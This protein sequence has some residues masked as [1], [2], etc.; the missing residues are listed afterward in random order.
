MR[1][2]LLAL[3][4][5]C[6]SWSLEA[7]TRLTPIQF[8]DRLTA[9][10]DSLFAGGQAWGR[11]FNI[12]H[13][14]KAYSSLRP[15][16]EYMAKYITSSIARVNV[17]PDV[18]NSRPLRMA[19]IEFLRYEMRMVTE[20]F[21]PLEKLTASSTKEELETAFNNL[22]TLAAKEDEQ[23]AK[24][25]AAQETYAKENGFRIETEEEAAKPKG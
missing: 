8:N 15:H 11:Q 5:V 2:L 22:Q 3:S 12:A 21:V 25:A 10:T 13:K 19:M 23:L 9:I 4:I 6:F 17:M 1:A 20:A 7:Q 16:R 18:N 14:S 24:V